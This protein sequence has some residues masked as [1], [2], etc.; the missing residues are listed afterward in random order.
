MHHIAW[1]MSQ[2]EVVILATQKH[3]NNTSSNCFQILVNYENAQ[4]GRNV[5]RGR[6]E[7]SLSE[8]SRVGEQCN[9][10]V[11]A[12]LAVCMIPV[13]DAINKVCVCVC[14]CVFCER[15]GYNSW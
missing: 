14:V 6:Q 12:G 10:L 8:F 13:H 2:R 15:A 1:K 7:C 9:D 5:S 3:V 4:L 11:L